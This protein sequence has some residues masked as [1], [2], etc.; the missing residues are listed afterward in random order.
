MRVRSLARPSIRRLHVTIV[1]AHGSRALMTLR[2]SIIVR[3]TH[4]RSH[5]ER[6]DAIAILSHR[7]M[8]VMSAEPQSDL[9]WRSQYTQ[10]I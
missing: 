8:F 3:H 5:T 10:Y 2:K 9:D 4:I 7:K 6:E 1:N